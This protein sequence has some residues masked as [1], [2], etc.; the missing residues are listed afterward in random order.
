MCRGLYLGYLFG[1]IFERSLI[2][3]LLSARTK[4]SGHGLYTRYSS[5]Y[6]FA[7]PHQFTLTNNWLPAIISL[8][9]LARPDPFGT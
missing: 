1:Y 5:G 7:G 3:A 8:S 9:G 4:D 2:P 6:I